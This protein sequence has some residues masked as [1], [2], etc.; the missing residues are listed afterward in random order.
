M[1]VGGEGQILGAGGDGGQGGTC[2][3]TGHLVVQ[4]Q[5]D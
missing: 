3:G 5:V 1:D 4:V 2:L